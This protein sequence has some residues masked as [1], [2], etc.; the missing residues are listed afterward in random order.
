MYV[1]MYVC[2]YECMYVLYLIN[3]TATHREREREKNI[4]REEEELRDV[5]STQ[6]FLG[7]TSGTETSS[8]G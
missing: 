8:G 2:V 5:G 6:A 1:C 7:E 4:E 3:I